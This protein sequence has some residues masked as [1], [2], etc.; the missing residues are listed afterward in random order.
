MP[1]QAK[2]PD[3]S[4]LCHEHKRYQAGEYDAITFINDLM[5]YIAS[6]VENAQQNGIGIK[7]NTQPCLN[8]G[9]PLDRIKKKKKRVLLG[10]LRFYRELQIGF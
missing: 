8:C 7:A 6:E 10:L 9:K 1:D 3:M 5:G 4:T 2:Y